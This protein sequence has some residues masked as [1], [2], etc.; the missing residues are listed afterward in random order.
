LEAIL[1]YCYDNSKE[2]NRPLRYL[3]NI[4]FEYLLDNVGLYLQE[5]QDDENNETINGIIG[6]LTMMIGLDKNESI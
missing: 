5:G 4:G 2:S 3:I 6:E 1:L